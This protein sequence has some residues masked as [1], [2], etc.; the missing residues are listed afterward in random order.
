MAYL[1]SINKPSEKIRITR[2][3]KAILTL[4][5]TEKKPLPVK[6][7]KNHLPYAD[8]TIHYAVQQLKHLSLIEST[9]NI[10]DMRERRYLLAAKAAYYGFN[11]FR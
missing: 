1:S 9:Y 2:S 7:I 3:A 11:N 10:N 5:D 8:R 6:E 4:L